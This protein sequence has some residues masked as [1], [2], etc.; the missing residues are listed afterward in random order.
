MSTVLAETTAPVLALLR[1]PWLRPLNDSAAIDDLLAMTG[2]TLSLSRIRARVVAAVRESRD[3]RTLVLKPNALWPGHRAGQHVTVEVEIGGRR[4]MRTF[5][6]S[7]PRRRDGLLAITVKRHAGGKVSTWWNDVARAGDVVTLAAPGGEFVLPRALPSHLVFLAA[8]SGITPV[9]AMLRELDRPGAVQPR[10]RLLYSTATAADAIFGKELEALAARSPWLEMTLHETATHGRI[11]Q[12]HLA[13]LA[14]DWADALVY[15]CGPDGFQQTVRGAW[16]EAG[17]A[18]NL[19][20]ERFSLASWA[21]VTAEAV[22][23]EASRSGIRFEAKPGETLLA[24][25]ERAGLAPVY[26]CRMGVCHTCKCAK[27]SGRTS[28]VRDGRTSDD[29][30]GTIQLCIST[31]VTPVVLEL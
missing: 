25:A 30:A 9:M 28:D 23:V 3:A 20:F 31:A 7:S 15:V 14:R 17:L 18:S 27:I 1:S 8:G 19:R 10:V 11:D 29:G 13:P 12:P 5:S 16:N 24:A 26:G 6:L 4:L 2:T 22:P 21:P